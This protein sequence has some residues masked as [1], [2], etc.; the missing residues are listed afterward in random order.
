[1]D[2]VPRIRIHN[3]CFCVSALPLV[4]PLLC[5]QA[6]FQFQGRTDV[7]V[8]AVFTNRAAFRAVLYACAHAA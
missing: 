4:S 1:M 8:H 5:V 2:G 7:H 6:G 3:R